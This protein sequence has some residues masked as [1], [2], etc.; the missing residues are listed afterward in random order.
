MLKSL[1]LQSI[2]S[3]SEVVQVNLAAQSG[4]MGV[5]ANHVPAIEPLKPGIIEV[6]ESAGQSK[7]WFGGC[8]S[9]GVP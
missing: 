3:S 2:Y 6:I 7:K 1:V 8:F 9:A 5:L 4:D